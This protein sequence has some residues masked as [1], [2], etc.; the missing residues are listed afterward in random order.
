M[1]AKRNR[2]QVLLPDDVYEAIATIARLSN[3]SQSGFIAQILKTE[4]RTLIQLS[5]LMLEA[6]EAKEKLSLTGKLRIDQHIM[7]AGRHKDAAFA[8]FE[9]IHLII[10]DANNSPDPA[11]DGP[12]RPGTGRESP[13]AINK[14][15]K[16]TSE[17]G[18]SPEMSKHWR[19][20]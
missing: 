9:R 4:K 5:H 1:P 19:D 14:G 20:I 8:N 13:L 2:I 7:D 10:S 16:I 17:G 6:Q 15:A 18:Q 11:G 3:M 12:A